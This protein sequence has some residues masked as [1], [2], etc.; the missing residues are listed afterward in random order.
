MCEGY[1]LEEAI[2]GAEKIH[3]RSGCNGGI[4]ETADVNV[5][6]KNEGRYNQKERMDEGV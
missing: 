1:D 3:L 4:G 5:I 6:R 2:F